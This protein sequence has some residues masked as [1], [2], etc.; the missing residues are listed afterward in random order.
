MTPARIDPAKV[1]SRVQKTPKITNPR[2]TMSRIGKDDSQLIHKNRRSRPVR[3]S[4]LVDVRR[5]M[6]LP[7]GAIDN[8]FR[9]GISA[10]FSVGLRLTCNK[11]SA[12]R[13][14]IR[15]RPCEDRAD[16]PV[17]R[18]VNGVETTLAATSCR[19]VKLAAFGGLSA[20]SFGLKGSLSCGQPGDWDPVRRTGNVVEPDALKERD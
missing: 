9:L 14:Q 15:V 5:Y 12:S 6:T 19:G 8:L 10:V 1:A 17:R 16:S 18:I 7:A 20:L 3:I 11:K 13:P 4:W 2:L